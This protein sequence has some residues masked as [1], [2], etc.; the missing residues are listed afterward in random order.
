MIRV[1]QRF[2]VT[3]TK[4]LKKYGVSYSLYIGNESSNQQIQ[5]KNHNEN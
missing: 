2:M 1:L 3:L 5:F 4:N